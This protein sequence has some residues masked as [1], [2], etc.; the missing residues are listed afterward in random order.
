[1]PAEV[2]T[3]NTTCTVNG[4]FYVMWENDGSLPR[5]VPCSARVPK[6]SHAV[7]PYSQIIPLGVLAFFSVSGHLPELLIPK[8]FRLTSCRTL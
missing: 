7:C 5:Q 6:N 4:Y 3:D 1:M 8:S 2:S